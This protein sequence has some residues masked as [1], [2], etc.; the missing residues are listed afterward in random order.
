[1]KR[2]LLIAPY[3]VVPPRQGA[4]VRVYNIALHLAR[5]YRVEL[6]AQQV[7]RKNIAPSLAPVLNRVTPTLEE[8]STRNPLDLLLY[9]GLFLKLHCPPIWQ[10][11][12]LRV[13]APPWLRAAL[14]RADLI[15]VETHWQFAWVYSQVGASRPIILNTQNVEADYYTPERL[16][17]PRAA[18]RLFAD[19]NARQEAFAVRRASYVLAV[20]P[21]DKARFGELYGLDPE[22][23]ALLP[24]GVD[25]GRFAPAAPALRQQRKAALGLA[26]RAVFVFTG[27]ANRPNIESVR[28]ILAWARGWQ[29]PPACFLIMGSVSSAFPGFEHPNVRLTG[30]VDD[31]LGHY[32]AC[33][34]ALNPMVWGGGTNLKQVEY[35]A[36]GLPVVSTAVGARG[37]PVVDEVHGFVRDLEGFPALLA[38]MASDPAAYWP[39]GL[40]GRELAVRMFDWGALVERL[41][42]LYEALMKGAGRAPAVARAEVDFD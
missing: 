26:G 14:H 2:L 38:R 39:V 15:Q 19:L 8:Y 16:E 7:L 22:R 11:G 41:L 36:M 10:S 24:N 27:S 13:S 31:V 6:F 25:C 35:M 17:V 30:F 9:A 32:Q 40:R 3:A 29:G 37:V 20:S 12:M 34:V 28:R 5:H 23:C 42:P 18:A 33:D 1:M 4:P 21:A